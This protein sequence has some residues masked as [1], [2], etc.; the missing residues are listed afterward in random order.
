MYDYSHY[1]CT[2]K[3][4]LRSPSFLYQGRCEKE[5]EQ[6]LGKRREYGES[7]PGIAGV[8][9]ALMQPRTLYIRDGHKP[10][11]MQSEA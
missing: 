9:L 5:R 1:L 8:H 3:L 11:R 10:M 4:G 2:R 6:E 7:R